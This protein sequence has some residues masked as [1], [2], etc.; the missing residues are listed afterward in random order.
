MISIHPVPLHI[1]YHTGLNLT[2][3]WQIFGKENNQNNYVNGSIMK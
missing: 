1:G 2:F 3:L